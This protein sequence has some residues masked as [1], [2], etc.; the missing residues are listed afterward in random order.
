[1]SDSLLREKHKLVHEMIKGNARVVV[2]VSDSRAEVILKMLN[3][4]KQLLP[5]LP[6]P[7]S[8]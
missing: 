7:Q 4:F 1:M 8:E 2:R 3:M 6:Q 5:P